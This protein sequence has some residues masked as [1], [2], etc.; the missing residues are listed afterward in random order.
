M[1]R[2]AVRA[3]L[4]V[5]VYS[6]ALT[7]AWAQTAV[8]A[9]PPSASS[10]AFPSQ[11]FVYEVLRQ[12]VRFENNGTGRTETLLHVR[13]QNDAGVQHWGNLTLPYASATQR[14]DVLVFEVH[15]P[16][17]Q[18]VR[19]DPSAIQDAVVQPEAGAGVFHDL[20]QKHL[21]VPALKAGD[22]LVLH[23]AWTTHT[24]VVQ[25]QFFLLHK[26]ADEAIVLDERLEIDIPA[27]R[28]VVTAVSPTAPRE[29]TDMKGTV[30]NGRRVY[31]WQHSL[32]KLPD[33]SASDNNA[34]QD[35][36][37][38]KQPDV[39]L[40]TFDTWEAVGR[41]YARL[42]APAAMADSAVRARTDAVV[43]G[44]TTDE[45]K[46][47][48]IYEYVSQEIRYVSL[49]FGVTRYAPHP[50]GTV[51][52]NQYG[53][54]KDKHTLLAAMLG[55]AGIEAWPVL[56]NTGRSVESKVP[57]PVEFD[58]LFTVLPRGAGPQDWVWLDTT[59]GVAPYRMLLAGLRDKQVLVVPMPPPVNGKDH[60]S[61]RLMT[62]PAAPAVA[63]ETMIEI[64][65]R[66]NA[67][68]VLDARVRQTLRG[69]AELLMRIVL[70]A[71]PQDKWID[72]AR[73]AAE[74][75]SLGSSVSDARIL[76][77]ASPREPLVTE[78]TVR[79]AGHL[80]PTKTG[81]TLAVP[82]PQ[83]TFPAGSE[84]AWEKRVKAALGG[85]EIIVRR[86][87]LDL[88]SGYKA[89]APLGVTL[90]REPLEYK[91]TYT[92][93][94]NRVRAERTLRTR[95]K[96][97]SAAASGEYLAAVR[98][99][100]ADEAQVIEIAFDTGAPPEIPADA[101]ADEL[102]KV[103]DG[104]YDRQDYQAAAAFWKRAVEIDPKHLNAWDGLGLAYEQLNRQKEAA[105]AFRKQIEVRPFHSQAH[106]DLGRVLDD[107]GDH[108]GAVAAFTKHLEIHPLD[109]AA[110]GDLGEVLV[111][112]ER[113]AE[114]VPHLEKAAALVKNDAW[115]AAY[116]A[117]AHIAMK[118]FDKARARIDDVVRMSPPPAVSTY[119]AWQLADHAHDLP[120]AAELAR[121]SLAALAAATGKLEAAG[122]SEQD[123]DL[124]ER[125]AW[126]WDALGWIHFHHGD[127]PAA[128]RYIRASWLIAGE[129][130][131]AFHL[132]RVYEKQGRTT[133]AATAYLLSVVLASDPRDD[134][135]ERVKVYFG[136]GANMESAAAGAKASALNE[137][138]VRLSAEAGSFEGRFLALIGPSGTLT[139]VA[140]RGPEQPPAGVVEALRKAQFRVR[141]PEETTPRLPVHIRVKCAAAAQGCLAVIDLPRSGVPEK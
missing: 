32:L 61:A 44:L 41:W 121:K 108:E 65:G 66:V 89:K 47:R 111:R 114:A 50:A 83:Q 5:V 116:L 31:R 97:V 120:R 7:G 52:A 25:G 62:T 130:D 77:L 73:G 37:E 12:K 3:T 95:T 136:P 76:N 113:Y 138:V 8:P 86:M 30:A 82:F 119:L 68:G 75:L 13:V 87:R 94:A 58:H 110:L 46:I 129:D 63:N 29:Q 85:P 14:F 1:S 24:P 98:G 35:Q 4:G 36:E 132:A 27:G 69:D 71:V 88:P 18:I 72:V 67:L 10:P 100:R 126:T 64:E 101:T 104:A 140:P 56:A 16:D 137:R 109:G 78:F 139:D 43:K 105:D 102:Y 133:D 112:K 39:R 117:V 2:C 103:G 59:P 54:C 33:A 42:A 96:D 48:A 131:T 55:A 34:E 80:K 9:A 125:V 134:A 22:R 57:S 40:S 127:L 91:S 118:Q 84:S 6:V 51:L 38:A 23:M 17:G 124:V 70:R 15:K 135:K 81:A 26:F 141:F 115:T 90:A 128:E 79:H 99:V 123:F 92:V 21:T 49:S 28:S 107:L 11:S 74:A 45:E 60:G 19:G 122:I 93:E 53:D 20:R 106:K